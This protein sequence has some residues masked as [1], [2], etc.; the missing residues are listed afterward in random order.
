MA[1]TTNPLYAVTNK[2]KDIEPVDSYFELVIAKLGLTPLVEFVS[3]LLDSLVEMISS[4]AMFV[5]IKEF[6]DSLIADIESIIAQ[7]DPVLNTLF[8]V[9]QLFPFD[10][11]FAGADKKVAEKDE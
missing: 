6:I 11:L 7:F 4:Y 10:A 2:G 3:E 1:K 5:T 8:P 9:K